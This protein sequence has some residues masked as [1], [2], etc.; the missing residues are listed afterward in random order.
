[1]RGDACCRWLLAA[2]DP[3]E[4]HVHRGEVFGVGEIAVLVPVGEDL[5]EQV[6]GAGAIDDRAIGRF[7]LDKSSRIVDRVERQHRD[8]DRCARVG[9]PTRPTSISMAAK[10]IAE[11]A[12]P[13]TNTAAWP[14]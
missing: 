9:V 14:T 2:F 4:E 5:Q 3:A 13:Y 10:P 6:G 11:A 8:G 1:M 12:A 7:E